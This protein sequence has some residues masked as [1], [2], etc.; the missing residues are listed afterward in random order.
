MN[1]DD[2]DRLVLVRSLALPGIEVMAGYN[3]RQP[4]HYFHQRYAL[5]ACVSAASGVRYRGRHDHLSDQCVMVLEPGE[6]HANTYV[7]KPTN[8]K[9]LFIEAEVLDEWLGDLRLSRSFHFAPAP[10]TDDLLLFPALYRACVSVES[11][12]D[13]LEQQSLLATCIRAFA[14]HSEHGG[15]ALECQNTRL[16]VQRAK[17]HLQERFDQPVTL[18][19]LATVSRLSQFHL[20][21][22]FTKYVGLSPHAY[23][24]HIRVESGRALLR[25][26]MSAAEAALS[27]GFADQSHFTRHFKRIMRVTPAEYARS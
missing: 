15:D 13:A 23:Q 7:S 9:V 11:A 17:K 26:G 22:A 16:A 5:T 19:D 1:S 10:I 3:C 4:F 20:A 12:G 18:V 2:S 27:V 6:T 8:F 24:I 21:H 25:K 14:R